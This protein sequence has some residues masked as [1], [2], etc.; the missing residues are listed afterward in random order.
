MWKQVLGVETRLLNQEW[1]VYLQ[2][3][4]L[5]NTQVFRAGWIGD[6]ND[7][8]TFAE[9]LHSQNAQNDSGWVN[10]RYDELLDQAALEIDLEKRARL[11]EEAE[12]VL[13]EDTPIIPVYFYISKHLIKPWVGGFVPNIMDHT[14]TKDLYI[15]RHD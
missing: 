9:L 15:L 14:Y 7:A 11:L 10:A 2:T 13:L 12:R 4:E 6:Y 1:K 8:N 5:K 3:R